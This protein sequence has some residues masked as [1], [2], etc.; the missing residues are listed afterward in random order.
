MRKEKLEKPFKDLYLIYN[1][2]STDDVDN[3]KNSI[4]YQ[5]TE[6][7]KFAK[8]ERLPVATK[9]DI[10]GFCKGGIINERHT[11]FK[12]DDQL[13]IGE[14][15]RIQYRIERP[16]FE[17]L[18]HSLIRG[19]FKGVIFL[20]W[21]RASRNKNDDNVIRKLMKFKDVDIQFVQ[22]KYDDTSAG[23]LHKDVDGMFAQHHSRNTSEKVRNTN[24][25]LR[26]EGICTYRAP[27]GYENNG[28]PRDKPFDPIRAPLVKQIFEKYSE[29][30]W[31]LADLTKWANENGLTTRPVRRKRT[32]EEMLRDEEV[33]IDPITRPITFNYI[34]KI[35]TN[36]FYIGKVL[37]NNG[38]Y[39]D[40]ISHQPLVS[41]DLFYRVQSLLK[42]RKVSIHY[43]NKLYYAYRGMVRCDS[44]GR[45][46]T[47]YEQKGIEY[48]GAR[49]ARECTN[50]NR[51]INS[52]F[53][54][55]KV[56]E[57]MFK[58]VFTKE[59]L[60]DIDRQVRNEVSTLEES[61]VVKI[62][63]L[64]RQKRKLNEDLSYLRNN[65]LSLLK[66][67]VYSGEDYLAEEADIAQKVENIRKEEENCD[68]SMREVVKDVVFLSE[69][70]EDAYLYYT[71]AKAPEKQRIIT[72]IFSELT[73]SEE[74]MKYKC[75]NGFKVLE[76]K[77]SLLCD[78]ND[79]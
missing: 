23:E 49:C 35:L 73:V 55:A 20:C 36:S 56:G 9:V 68:V 46:Y 67:G 11:G 2:K 29:G 61:R 76:N 75:R 30:T 70:L 45:V 42:H 26:S 54:E 43:K 60:E 57:I 62:K 4:A 78:L 15:G 58:M 50:T 25:K 8:R 38:I 77:K 13:D 53:I 40:S 71:L 31:S 48:Y 34:H 33:K 18:V 44:C 3:Q 16:K 14:D 37:G 52:D 79:T 17:K 74:T 12:E 10:P 32:S 64:E 7:I 24:K 28:D 69:L 63:E 72:K 19:E 21:D 59:E 27:I 65:K 39:V 41:E 22:T 6:A 5:S 47:P 51:N 1:R 66:N